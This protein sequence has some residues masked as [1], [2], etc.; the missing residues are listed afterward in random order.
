MAKL[1]SPTIIKDILLRHGFRFTKALGQ[2]FL[3]DASVCPRMAALCGADKGTGV[4][5]IGPGI[6]VLTCELAKTAQRVVAVEID[7]RLR[8]VLSETLGDLENVSIVYGDIMKMELRS[9]I[10]EQFEGKEICVCA[11]LPYYITSPVLMRLLEGHLPI[12]SITVMVQ[13]EAAQRICARPGTRACG[14]VSISVHYHCQPEI[15]FKV[16]RNSFMPPPGVD[17]SVIRLNLWK[18]PP[19]E[20][21]DEEWFF[22]VARSAFSQRR[23][24]AVNSISSTL[25]LPKGQVEAAVAEAGLSKSVRAEQL[26]LGQFAELSNK[27]KKVIKSK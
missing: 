17:S 6:G 19:V 14:A 25:Q 3:I 8:P 16:G 23:K 13:Q 18:H 27:L 4:L 9:L 2:N 24:T 26:Q 10:E 22:K 7:Q 11:N 12:R 5:E 20:V 21:D 15:L 1:S